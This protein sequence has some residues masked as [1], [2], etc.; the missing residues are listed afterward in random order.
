L[1]IEVGWGEGFFVFAE[2]ELVFWRALDWFYCVGLD[3]HR[4]GG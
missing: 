2:E 3:I 1:I 4:K